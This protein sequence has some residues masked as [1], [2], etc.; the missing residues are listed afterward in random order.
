[1][2]DAEGAGDVAVLRLEQAAVV[3]V[4]DFHLE[5]REEEREGDEVK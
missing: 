1:M 5:E 4:L 3:L 2:V